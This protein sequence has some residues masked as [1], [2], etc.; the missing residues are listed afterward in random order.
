MER[1]ITLSQE[2]QTIVN[3]I[4]DL[5]RLSGSVW[6]ILSPNGEETERGKEFLN[7]TSSLRESLE[8]LI[9]DRFD[10]SMMELENMDGNEVSF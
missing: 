2:T 5:E 10:T 3:A 8:E 6:R 1:T 7:R 4:L 9:Q